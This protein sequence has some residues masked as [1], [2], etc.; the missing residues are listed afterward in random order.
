MWNRELPEDGAS[1]VALI[2]DE[3]DLSLGPKTS[4]GGPLYLHRQDWKT[5]AEADEVGISFVKR[6]RRGWDWTSSTP[7][8]SSLF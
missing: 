3:V 8:R 1:P 4:E 5:Q 2:G 7:G 6:R